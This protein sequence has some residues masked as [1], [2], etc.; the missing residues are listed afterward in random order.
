[1]KWD[2]VF[3]IPSKREIVGYRNLNKCRSPYL[4]GW[5]LLPAETRYSQYRVDFKADH[6]PRGTYCCLG[7]WAMDLSAL[8]KRYGSASTEYWCHGYAGFQKLQDGRMASIMSFW[9]ITCRTASGK[10]TVIRPKILYPS[11]P[12]G[13]ESF[14][15]E[16]T[17]ARCIVPFAWEAGHWYRMR[18]K[19]IPSNDGRK[20]FVEQW[21]SDLET[22]DRR[23]LCRYGIDAA[24]VN[25]RGSIAFFLENFLPETA[26]EVRSMEVRNG[27][28]LDAD[29]G[30]WQSFTSAQVLPEGGLPVYEGSYEFGA[31]GNLVWMIT[32][33]VGGDWFGNGK[34][35]KGTVY[36]LESRKE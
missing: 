32:S 10:V 11:E 24:G 33:G 5:F 4:A 2:T 29:S 7:N 15:G 30:Q 16:G 14:S 9:D 19:C 8:E 20:T 35:R 28:Y 26:G 25:L 21:V 31:S 17:G 3:S 22:G 13:G 1:M 6:L 34:G 36:T 23:L 27:A 18:L 12:I